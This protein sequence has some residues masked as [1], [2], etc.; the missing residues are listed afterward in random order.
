MQDVE[1][2]TKHGTGVATTN[3]AASSDGLPVVVVDGVP[4]VPT[5][6][7]LVRLPPYGPENEGVHEMRLALERAGYEVFA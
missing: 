6:A 5:Q 2:V 7:G 1:V 3:H 4:Y